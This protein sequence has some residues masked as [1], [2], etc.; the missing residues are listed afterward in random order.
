MHRAVILLFVGLAAGADHTSARSAFGYAEDYDPLAPAG[1]TAQGSGT[2]LAQ[3]SNT[4]TKWHLLHADATPATESVTILKPDGTTINVRVH[5]NWQIGQVKR[6]IELDTENA[7]VA[8]NFK[9]IDPTS[10]FKP[11]NEYHTLTDYAIKDQQTLEIELVR[12]VDRASDDVCD[13]SH[14]ECKVFVQNGHEVLTHHMQKGYMAYG[15]KFLCYRTQADD[16]D[17]MQV[18]TC[19]CKCTRTNYQTSPTPP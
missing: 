7:F 17:A 4:P 14:V 11:L 3:S 13:A 2:G 6:Q 9:L 16:A 18:K 1:N 10:P 19:E 15:G 12:E 5:P 8:N